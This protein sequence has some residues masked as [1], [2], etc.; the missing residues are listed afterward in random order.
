MKIVMTT[1]EETWLQR[2]LF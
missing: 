2:I 1:K